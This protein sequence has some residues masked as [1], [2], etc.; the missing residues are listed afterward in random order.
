M[1]IKS[2]SQLKLAYLELQAVQTFQNTK[3][4]SG[5][6]RTEQAAERQI[7]FLKRKIDE[8]NLES[9]EEYELFFD[10][11]VKD[12]AWRAFIQEYTALKADISKTELELN[13]LK[14]KTPERIKKEA[15]EEKKSS[16]NSDSLFDQQKSQL[17]MERD[18]LEAERILI[19]MKVLLI[20]DSIAAI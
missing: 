10:V 16:S 19:F 20:Q 5:G 17:D 7:A 12:E 2:L 4:T 13:T 1:L 14:V 8:N 3:T 15:E 11:Q 18:A 6:Q 9:L